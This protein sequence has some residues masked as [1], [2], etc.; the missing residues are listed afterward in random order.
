MRPSTELTD[1]LCAALTTANSTLPHYKQLYE[2]LRQQIID[3]LLLP[4]MCLPSSRV[5]AKQLVLSRN[6]VSAAIDQLC[7]EGYAAARAKSGVYILAT[8]PINWQINKNKIISSKI[9]K[10]LSTR[11]EQIAKQADTPPARGAFAGGVPDL[12]QFPFAL[13]QRYIL[14][15]ARNPKL[16]W[17]MNTNH[18]GDLD[19]RQ[20]LANYLRITRG[21]SCT[22]MQ[23]LITHGTQH[24]LA[25][26]ADL[27]ADQNDAV[28]MENPGYTGARC[29]FTAADL[30]IINQPVDAEGIFPAENAWQNPPRFIYTTPSHQFP[31]G[32][33]MSAA[34][35]R[36][37]L[38]RA[39]LHNTLIIED[40]YDSEFRYEAAPIAALHALAPN[41]VIY[42]GTFSKMLFP[43]L[44]IGRT[45][46]SGSSRLPWGS[47]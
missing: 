9:K 4:G 28:W 37:L 21:I 36:H 5:L 44:R 47:I 39:A 35:R 2:A 19:L 6:T 45:V 1:Q 8:T 18:G 16:D 31:T 14:R 26:C 40:D 12:K 13:W 10:G 27:L 32:V 25:L 11:G 30:T 46:P 3:G 38:A 29:A 7:A 15:H 33:V 17:Q 23:I 42:L 24:S 43:A 41:Q 34:R 22:A 20:T